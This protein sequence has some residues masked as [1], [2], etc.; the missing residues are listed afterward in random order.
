MNN[1]VNVYCDES[2][3]LINDGYNIAVLGGISIDKSK[4]REINTK[5]R[6]IKRKHGIY[7]FAEIKWVKVSKNKIDMYKDLVDLFFDND[8]IHF[9]AVVVNNKKKV[10]LDA[11]GFDYDDWY[12]RIYYLLLREVTEIDFKY[13]IYLDKKDNKGIERIEKLREVLHRS[14]YDFYESTIKN[15]QLL[16]SDQVEIMQLA[17]LL[18]GA[19]AYKN[20][21]L[22]TNEGK[23]EL[24]KYIEDKINHRLDVSSSKAYRKFNIF[25]WEP[26][27]V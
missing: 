15:I 3:H 19:V 4:T 2:C 9:R 22:E 18:I 26:R 21:H 27:N 12:Y 23:V 20:R 11:F 24:V 14:L 25:V 1:E 13:Y 8:D 16:R 5:I 7:K 6:E 17:D 10:K